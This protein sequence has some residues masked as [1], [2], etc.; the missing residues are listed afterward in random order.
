MNVLNCR[1]VTYQ[2]DSR[3]PKLSGACI[4]KVQSIAYTNSQD[5]STATR[6]TKK[7]GAHNET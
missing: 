6:A 2:S 4:G 1:Q 3:S 5:S 7:D